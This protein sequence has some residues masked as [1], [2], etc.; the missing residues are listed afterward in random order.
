[1]QARAQT[2]G[3]FLEEWFPGCDIEAGLKSVQTFVENLTEVVERAV[4]SGCEMVERSTSFR[5]RLVM[6]PY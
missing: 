1:M 6:N 2:I 4:M 5:P 3:E